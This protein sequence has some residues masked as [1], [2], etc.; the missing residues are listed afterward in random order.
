MFNNER[1]IKKSPE[2]QTL[3]GA[4]CKIIGNLSGEGIIKIDGSIEGDTDWVDDI[5]IGESSNYSG[6]ISCKNA[7]VEGV[8]NGD[9]TCENNLLI[10]SSGKVIGNVTVKNL[11]ILKGGFLD[12]KCTMI[13][14]M[15][16]NDLL[17]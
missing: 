15:P 1:D 10:E 7:T 2:I 6:N 3:I 16:K 11:E 4:D 17:E 9:I 12:G 13:V 14:E 8:V 5:I